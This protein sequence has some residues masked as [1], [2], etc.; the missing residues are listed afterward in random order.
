MSPPLMEV[1]HYRRFK[2][3]NAVK[4]HNGVMFNFYL[5]VVLPHA[6]NNT[7]NQ[8]SVGIRELSLL[9]IRMRR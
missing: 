3:G 5:A 6:A 8:T 7:C 2:C 1:L 9:D 4:I